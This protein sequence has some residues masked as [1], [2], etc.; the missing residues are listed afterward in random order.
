M[1][2][3]STILCLGPLRHWERLVSTLGLQWLPVM[4][5]AYVSFVA[6]LLET[7]GI[8]TFRALLLQSLNI[9]RGAVVVH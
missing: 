4:A 9:D 3:T 7:L 2:D 1:G 8:S 6:S 5:Q